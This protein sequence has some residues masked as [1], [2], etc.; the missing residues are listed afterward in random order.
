MTVL[1][2]KYSSVHAPLKQN[3]PCNGTFQES[4]RSGSSEEIPMNTW[5][6][7]PLVALSSTYP[8]VTDRRGQFR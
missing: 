7:F 5:F 4:R 2:A 8:P 1:A 3:N 6:L